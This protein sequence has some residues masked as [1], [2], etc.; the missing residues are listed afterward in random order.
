MGYS[1]AY[2]QDLAVPFPEISFFFRIPDDRGVWLREPLVCGGASTAFEATWRDR[3]PGIPV[4]HGPPGNEPERQSLQLNI[5]GGNY[6][7]PLRDGRP[8]GQETRVFRALHQRLRGKS[9][10]YRV[11]DAAGV[12]WQ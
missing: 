7:E 4:E 5:K 9:P 3:T 8:G 10:G 6:V 2:T 11:P 1:I 12:A